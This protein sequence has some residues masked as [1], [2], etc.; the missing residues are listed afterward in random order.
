MD[1]DI[2][3]GRARTCGSDTL[4]L[5]AGRRF[6]PHLKRL[7]E[8]DEVP[9]HGLAGVH[10]RA[11]TDHLAS[12]LQTLLVKNGLRA[13]TKQRNRILQ[14]QKNSLSRR[15]TT[16]NIQPELYEDFRSGVSN[17]RAGIP[18]PITRSLAG[19]SRT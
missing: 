17:S 1:R 15:T 16:L 4:R 8:L 6:A 10:L 14:Q 3:Q 7:G 18:F 2:S 9:L 13:K 12:E 19:L 5:I 11:E